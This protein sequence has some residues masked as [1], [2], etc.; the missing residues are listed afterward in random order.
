MS[1]FKK[2]RIFIDGTSC[3]A[4]S[5]L[6]KQMSKN[7]PDIVPVY[8]DFI[9]LMREEL[10]SGVDCVLESIYYTRWVNIVSNLPEDG[11]LYI[12]DRYAPI[13]TQIYKSINGNYDNFEVF[14]LGTEPHN[15]FI[16]INHMPPE[17]FTNLTKQR[18]YF[19][20]KLDNLDC[21]QHEQNTRFEKCAK[22][23]NLRNIIYIKNVNHV[24]SSIKYIT[25]NI[26]T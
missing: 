10:E 16:F 19:D 20:A 2:N 21:Y 3:S 22:I 17:D 12:I 25:S 1:F 9:D 13:S 11:N 6:I 18:G 15:L 5:T 26:A 23:L 8:V 7:N 24:E 4:K 14:P